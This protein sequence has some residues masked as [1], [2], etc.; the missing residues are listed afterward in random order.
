MSVEGTSARAR[1][2]VLACVAWLANPCQ[3]TITPATEGDSSPY[4]RR[5]GTVPETGRFVVVQ[6]I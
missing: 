2:G 1:A 5:T 4:R 6:A 3:P